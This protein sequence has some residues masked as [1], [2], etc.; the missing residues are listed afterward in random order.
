MHRMIF[1]QECPVPDDPIVIEL[2]IS[3]QYRGHDFAT[4]VPRCAAKAEGGF[5]QLGPSQATEGGVARQTGLGARRF[6]ATELNER[7]PA[8]F[9]RSHACVDVLVDVQLQMAFELGVEIAI[10]AA[11]REQAGEAQDQDAHGSHEVF[12]AGDR[13]R[14]TI[15][16]VRCHSRASFSR[17]RWPARVSR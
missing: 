14:A 10:A 3:L 13:K 2:P 6:Y 4:S 5:V 12:C 17:C 1:A 8:C 16:A 15:A 11:G 7:K 9:L